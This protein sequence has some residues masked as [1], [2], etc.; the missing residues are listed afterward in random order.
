M[1]MG[2][3]PSSPNFWQSIFVNGSNNTISIITDHVV[4]IDN[5]VNGVEYYNNAVSVPNGK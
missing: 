2:A 4:V 5:D 3:A 1:Y